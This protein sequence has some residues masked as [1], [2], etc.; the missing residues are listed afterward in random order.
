MGRHFA[1]WG[2][3]CWLLI[4]TMLVVVALLLSGVRGAFYLASNYKQG[5]VDWLTK[6]INVQLNVGQLN[7]RISQFR[8]TLVLENV[9][10]ELGEQQDYRFDVAEVLLQI[11]LFETIEHR[12]LVLSQVI[13]NGSDV[14]LPIGQFSGAG[15]S[16]PANTQRL[17]SDVFLNRMAQF[18]LTNSIVNLQ[19]PNDQHTL[20][21]DYL[22]WRNDDDLHQG[23]GRL[24]VPGDEQNGDL[25]FRIDLNGNHR[26][27]ASMQGQIYLDAD[28]LNLNFFQQWLPQLAKKRLSSD[29]SFEAWASFGPEQ[30]PQVTWQWRPSAIRWEDPEQ[31]GLEIEQG[32][33]VARYQ[34]GYWQLDKLPWTVRAQGRAIND[35]NL[36]AT[37]SGRHGEI[38]A[39]LSDLSLPDWAPLAGL[40]TSY[41]PPLAWQNIV[42][43]G[44]LSQLEVDWRAHSGELSYQLV[45][46]GV[47]TQGVGAIPT[48]QGLDAQ[49]HGDQY[50]AK[51]ALHQLGGEIH[52]P[53]QF[54]DAWPVEQLDALIDLD[55]SHGPL[56]V[57]S[58]DTLLHTQDAQVKAKWLLDWHGQQSLPLLSLSAE[59]DV[60]DA[61]RAHHYYPD[62][63]PDGV[64]SY[65]ARALQAGQADK[66]QVLW[67]GKLQAFPYDANDGMFQAFVP[68]TKARFEFGEDWPALE[69]LQLDLLFQNDGL[70][71]E[72]RQTQLGDVSAKRLVASIPRFQ[73]QMLQINS[74]LEGRADAVTA[75]LLTTPVKALRESM[76]QLPVTGNKVSGALSLSIPLNGDPV[77]AAGHV[78]FVNNR[79]EVKPVGMQVEGLSGRLYFNNDQLSS[80]GL[81]MRWRQL[82]L[83]LELNSGID[84]Q[85]T[86]QLELG[87]N[88][89]WPLSLTER[90]FNLPLAPVTQGQLGWRGDLQLS[91][92]EEGFSYQANLSSD[93]RGVSLAMPEP[94]SK[95]GE[96]AWPTVISLSGDQDGGALDLEISER[97]TGR[98][99]FTS[100]DQGLV[101][102]QIVLHAG[103][104]SARNW[105]GEG[106]GLS[107]AYPELDL[108]SW[109]T[110]LKQR[111]QPKPAEP[112]QYQNVQLGMPKLQFVHGEVDRAQL[113]GQQLTQLN[114]GYLP[115]SLTQW[116]VEAD[117]LVASIAIPEADAY[118]Q[119]VRVLIE[120]ANLPDLSFSPLTGQGS[121]EP[122]EQVVKSKRDDWRL[123]PLSLTCNKC[124]VS[125]FYLGDMS[126]DLPIEGDRLDNGK[127]RINW[128]H[129][130]LSA[131]V[132]WFAENGAQRS[133]LVGIVNSGSSEHMLRDL[134][135]ASPIM[136]TPS[137]TGFTLNWQGPLYS[138]DVA[139]LNGQ[140]EYVGGEGVLTEVSDK[141]ARLFS[142]A[143]LDTVQRRLKLD[144]RDVFD[145]GMHYDSIS[146]TMQFE[147][148][149]MSNDDFFLDG[150]AGAMRGRGT[151]D[152]PSGSLDYRIS[153]APKFTSSLP[154]LTAFLVTPATGVAVLALQKLFE[155]MV[156]VVTQ[157]DFALTGNISEPELIELERVQREIEVP[158]EFRQGPEQ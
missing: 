125:H 116:R 86:Y 92:L 37:M 70:F 12:E 144:F 119:R 81:R 98:S 14:R 149:L 22:S 71:M 146:A 67:F 156:E 120:E 113:Y 103:A 145:K 142:L 150:V 106:L 91:L 3:R 33:L 148:G 151:V 141:G 2:R 52:V 64:Y 121:A 57:S 17:L 25:G 63:M 80:S 117:E 95:T 140:V 35:F 34:Q 28:E 56:K 111:P 62:V 69:D 6:D 26:D 66:A 107:F 131:D 38:S 54:Q 100:A 73:D 48:V 53:I 130:Q 1:I 58:R 18:K 15:G 115:R 59:V 90:A 97:L 8:P 83:A 61:G 157:I 39:S 46:D 137:R 76:Q 55:F 123:P 155:P 152:L 68:L 139:S 85:G 101:L 135:Y 41:T 124:Q 147:D 82:P 24:L 44:T 10:I 84:E 36:N 74:Q 93:L 65:L 132:N 133:E 128:G 87:L 31:Q 129:T 51:L 47:R 143:S 77:T 19:L 45:A 134:G 108:S 114:F 9:S 79:L 40:F 136:D 127:L 89:R 16:N 96:Q 78:D 30:V 72:S 153:F 11:D 20:Y 110:W 50:R 23:D 5:L 7:G 88:G 94:L 49:L 32:L 27:W 21:V 105:Q 118:D 126:L 42:T 13:L 122:S 60:L 109:I 99:R 112:A 29:L 4:V 154:V 43:A 138:P 104:G 102:E 75:Y 158:T